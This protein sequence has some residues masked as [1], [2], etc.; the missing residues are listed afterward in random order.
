[1]NEYFHA[2]NSVFKGLPSPI[3]A[4]NN[5]KED[6]KIIWEK[7][8]EYELL[9]IG[10]KSL[11]FPLLRYLRRTGDC[12]KEYE[13]FRRQNITTISIKDS[14]YPYRLLHL[15]N[16]YS[17]VL[18]YV[19]GKLPNEKKHFISVVGTRNMTAYGQFVTK[20]IVR[21]LASHEFVIVSGM[22]RG[23]DLNA[24]I[25]ALENKLETIAVLGFGINKI[26]Y[27]L[28]NLAQR[29]TENGA[30]VSEY[31]PN[32]SGQKHHFPIRNRIISGLSRAVIVVEAGEKSGALITA[33]LANDQGREVFSVPGNLGNEQSIG[34]NKLLQE[35]KANVFLNSENIFEV[36]SIQKSTQLN[37]NVFS[38]NEQ[39]IIKELNKGPKTKTEIIQN[40]LLPVGKISS[41]LTELELKD[42]IEKNRN[43]KF[44]LK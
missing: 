30:I 14:N 44:Y 16:Q 40:I 24:H 22:A 35:G 21:D 7:F 29:I 13:N 42:Y 39:F 26:P 25:A 2:W 43:G 41:I 23:V 18:L 12:F 32:L 28:Q 27:H 5:C 6:P 17:P 15:A 1:M 11:H 31:P 38:E 3:N 20:K 10:I 4:I 34:T 8:S 37:I 19:K 9:K 36:L 33:R